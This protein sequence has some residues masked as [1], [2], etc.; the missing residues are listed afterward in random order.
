M[1]RL[2][3]HKNKESLKTAQELPVKTATA[4]PKPLPVGKTKHTLRA[5]TSALVIACLTPLCSFAATDVNIKFPNSEYTEATVDM[6]VNATGGEIILKRVWENNRWYINPAWTHIR[7]ISDPLDN[8]VQ[9]IDRAGSHY[10]RSGNSD[11]YIFEQQFIRKTNTGWR[12]YDR[13]G[14]WITYDDK[15]RVTAY[16]DP[17]DVGATFKLDNE[18]RRTEVRDTFNQLIYK[19]EY[20]SEERL[21]KTTDRTGRS[22]QYHWQ[23]DRLINV[24]DVMGNDWTYKYDKSGQLIERVEPDGSVKIDYEY[25]PP[26]PVTA[27]ISGKEYTLPT[28]TP[29]NGSKDLSDFQT[30]RVSKLTD[31]NGAITLWNIQYNKIR[32]QYTVTEDDPLGKKTVTVYNNE[33]QLLTRHINGNLTAKAERE[34]KFV[35]Y[36]TDERGLTTAIHYDHI[37]HPVKTVFPDG[38]SV[39]TEYDYTLDKPVR[40]TDRQGTVTEWRYD[41]K[42]NLSTQIDAVGKPEQQISSY[43]YNSYGQPISATYGKDDESVTVGFKYDT[44]GNVTQ[45]TDGEGHVHQYSYTT[46]GNISEYQS[47]LGK[48]WQY[49]YNLAGHLTS[50]TNPLNETTRYEVDTLGQVT[51]VTNPLGQVTSYQYSKNKTGRTISQT[52]A[53][54]NTRTYDYD[55]NNNPIKNTSATNVG[56]RFT[57]NA[58]GHIK[59]LIDAADNVITLEYGAPGSSLARL[60][61]AVQFP[62][63]RETYQYNRIGLITEVKQHLDAHNASTTKI[64]YNLAGLPVSVTEPGDMTTLYEYDSLNRLVKETDALGNVT[65][66]SWDSLNRIST[67]TDANDNVHRYQYDKNN[68]LIKE[69]M[70]TGEMLAYQYNEDD[71]LIRYQDANGNVTAYQ[72]NDANQL[73]L[74]EITASGENTPEQTITYRYNKA[75]DLTE[76]I[77]T[78]A[79]NSHFLYVRDALGRTIQED[80]TYGSNESALRNALQYRFDEDSNLI[81]MTYPDNSEVTFSRE[82]GL[83]MQAELPNG[84]TIRWQNY[85]WTQPTEIQFPG[86]IQTRDYDALL[87]PLSIQVKAGDSLLMNRGYTYNTANNIIKRTTE[88]GEFN[89]VY[90]R[91]NRLTQATPPQALQLK[92]LPVESYAYDA[93]SNRTGSSHQPGEWQY[94][95]DNQL[96][97]MGI[98]GQLT[99]FDYSPNGHITKETKPAQ[100]K[101]YT[102]DAADRLTQVTADS[103]QIASYQY[104]PMG[105]R[106]SKT[107]NGETTWYLYTVEGLIAELDG[108][109]TMTVAYGWLPDSNW[110]TQPL[111]Q[112]NLTHNQTLQT[113]QFHYLH[114][115]HLGTPQIA[116]DEQGHISWKGLTE[117]F[118]KTLLEESNRITMN[119]RFPGQYYDEETDSHYNYFRDYNPAQGQYWQKDR[120]G[121]NGGINQYIYANNNP[122]IYIDPTGEAGF[123][124]MIYGGLA[125]AIGGYITGGVKGALVGGAVGAAVGFIIPQLSGKAGAIAGAV[126]VPAANLAGQAIGN[127]LDGKDPTDWCNY[128]F[129]ALAG[130]TVGGRLAYPMKAL[131][132]KWFDKYIH[133]PLNKPAV[134][135]TLKNTAGAATEGVITGSMELGGKKIGD[136]YRN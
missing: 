60:P 43:S 118:G 13:Q 73:I 10:Q 87:R 42:G 96:L 54:G 74:K 25:S 71:Q 44:F 3:N 21:I 59:E 78:G 98:N 129:W 55:L 57:Y 128:D 116:T 88:D 125:G 51:A 11:I 101:T 6:R 41:S 8:S 1:N 16:G 134:S 35:T 70:P 111:W 132:N 30:A 104:D 29:I 72:Y 53:L 37:R 110:G 119:L 80:I 24:T 19:F 52:D 133:K 95:I 27:I 93:V 77:Q 136:N 102:Y 85:N 62:T 82:K 20:D 5:I 69:V 68:N 92:G 86:T 49:S 28:I 61:I 58:N 45:Y 66:Q 94:G 2:I 56:Y 63:F 130:A 32:Q 108:Q 127:V 48:R 126:E 75:G 114:T 83:L 124:G 131:V 50:I 17:N 135:N 121:L 117:A 67:V 120:I 31:K 105:R 91:L 122:L 112:A 76:M 7:F 81:G 103:T 90:D 115:D 64:D 12:W 109:N 18:G 47:P 113:A 14:N 107:I 100:V 15:G 97:K 106:I 84:N 9:I 65:L 99:T 4:Q 89:Y 36:Q 22:V 123:A 46:D 79:T 33:G 38:A 23:G 39:T 34:G 40:F 26:A